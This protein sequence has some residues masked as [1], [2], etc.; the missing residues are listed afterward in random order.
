V[1][2]PL[3]DA[4]ALAGPLTWATV[5]KCFS[6]IG[7]YTF[8]AAV[9]CSNRC[10]LRCTSRW[11]SSGYCSEFGKGNLHHPDRIT[12]PGAPS[13]RDLFACAR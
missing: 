1:V 12:R 8:G 4:T 9:L 6:G 7:A 3:L 10:H 2:N 11:R 5:C 13:F